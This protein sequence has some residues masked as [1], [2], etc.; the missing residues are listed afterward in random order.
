MTFHLLRSTTQD[1]PCAACGDGSGNFTRCQC[2]QCP[3]Q[4]EIHHTN[5]STSRVKGILRPDS[6]DK[7]KTLRYSGGTYSKPKPRVKPMPAEAITYVQYR[8]PYGRTVGSAGSQKRQCRRSV[9]PPPSSRKVSLVGS[10]PLTQNPMPSG[11]SKNSCLLS[12]KRLGQTEN[13]HQSAG[14]HISSSVTPRMASLKNPASPNCKS[15]QPSSANLNTDATPRNIDSMDSV[16]ALAG[17]YGSSI[18]HSQDQ[19]SRKLPASLPKEAVVN[20][21]SP[22]PKQV[23]VPHPSKVPLDTKAGPSSKSVGTPDSG[24]IK[25]TAS[26]AGP[27]LQASSVEPALLNPT[28]VLSQKPMEVY[29]DTRAAAPIRQEPSVKPVLLTPIPVHSETSTDVYCNSRSRP[30]PSTN[31]L[32]KKSNLA[33]LQHKDISPMHR[34]QSMASTEHTAVSKE[35]NMVEKNISPTHSLQSMTHAQ[36]T[37]LPK[38]I[39]AGST[40]C[41]RS[42]EYA[43]E[44]KKHYQSEARWMGKFHVTGELTHTCYELE[45]HCPAVMDCRAYEASKQMPEILNLEAV[46]LSQLWPKKFKMEPPDDQDIRLWF[47]SSHQRP[48]RSFNHL[49]DK[50]SSHIGLLTSI[51]DA[52][53]AIFSSKL[54]APDYQRKNGELYFWGVFGKHLRKKWRKP[55]NHIQN[56][57]SNSSPPNEISSDRSEIGMKLDAIKGKERENAISDI[58]VTSD[59]REG[60]EKDNPMHVAKDSGIVRDSYEGIA[61]ALDLS[62]GKETDRDNDCV[63]VLRT[64]DSNPASSCTA[65]ASS[66]LNRCCSHDSANKHNFSLEDSACQPVDRSSA[67]SELMLDVPPGFS[68]DVPPGFTKAHRQLQ[69]K[70]TPVSYADAFASLVLDC[71]PGFPIDIPPGFT[72]VHRQLPAISPAG[73]EAGVSIHGT[74]TKPLI[75]FSLNVPSSVKMEVPPG[76]T[77]HAVKKEPRLPVDKTT[78]KQTTSRLTSGASPLVKGAAA[79]EMKITRDEAKMEQDE[80]SEEQECP[81]IRRLSDLYRGRSEDSTEVC[82]P[83]SSAHMTGKLF[84]DTGA[85]EKQTTHPRKRGRQ[86]SPERPAADTD[87]GGA[88]GQI[89]SRGR[90]T[91]P[92]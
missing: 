42:S 90:G 59:A 72:E 56:V 15:S 31:L 30:N 62:G 80:T 49:V 37:S 19:S 87:S 88:W 14:E 17:S 92:N 77:V 33:T 18:F 24:S 78:E 71:P 79:D 51:G 74:E 12:P 47:I 11:S 76:F 13:G 57:N 91:I 34:P 40:N 21:V 7:L 10:A 43:G 73:P 53:L 23:R 4:K 8:K 16:N 89:K 61:E 36:L 70:D 2:K 63:A 20:P 32:N 69:I 38:E 44:H 54:L 55:N 5:E 82:G 60:E 64:P 35:R 66:F 83:V 48:H 1:T 22:S 46:P 50:V 67:S 86:E 26:T 3:R 81:K 75:R 27:V 41:H 58:G 9:T 85:H 39:S 52:E 84:H 28:S 45:A 65:P 25:L 68:L 29:P 6:S